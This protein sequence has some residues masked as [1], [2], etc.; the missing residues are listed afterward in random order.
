MD[1]SY[2]NIDKFYK[3]DNVNLEKCL[4][5]QSTFEGVLVSDSN[6]YYNIFS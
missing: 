5:F 4:N 6:K 1:I 3:E 2:K